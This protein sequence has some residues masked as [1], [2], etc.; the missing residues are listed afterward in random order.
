[1]T[2]VFLLDAM[3]S[4]SDTITVDVAETIQQ[5]IVYNG[6]ALD[7]AFESLPAYRE[8]TQ[9]LAYLD[10]SVQLAYALMRMLE[11]WE[12]KHGAAGEMYVRRRAKARR[13]S[14]GS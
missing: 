8:G 13:R 7:V 5:Q 14:K 10:A 1:M 11:R 3:S 2:S 12:K 6:A 9:S 4:S